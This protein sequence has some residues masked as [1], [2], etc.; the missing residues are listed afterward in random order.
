[1]MD[2]YKCEI[3]KEVLVESICDYQKFTNDDEFPICNECFKEM[4]ENEELIESDNGEYEFTKKG[5]N[6][7]LKKIEKEL[8]SLIR[9]ERRYIKELEEYN[10]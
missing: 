5:L 2:S 3:C 1:M 10:K 6:V 9:Y 7:R 8:D 4:I